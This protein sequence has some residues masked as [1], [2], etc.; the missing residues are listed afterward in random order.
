MF[1]PNQSVHRRDV[2]RELERVFTRAC[3][4]LRSCEEHPNDPRYEEAAFHLAVWIHAEV[5]RIHPFEDGNGRTSRA[6]MNVVLH[7]LRLRPIAVGAIEQEY[8]AA[9]NHYFAHRDL[10]PLVD[11]LLRG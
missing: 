7:R 2:A 6:L 1:G 11:L 4:S 10:Q 5:V 9:L 8:N 3:Q